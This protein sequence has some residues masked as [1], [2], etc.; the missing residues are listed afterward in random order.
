MCRSRLEP[1]FDQVRCT[2][3]TATW[4]FP[5][6][7]DACRF[8]FRFSPP[9]VAALLALSAAD[10]A[11]LVAEVEDYTRRCATGAGGLSMEIPFLVATGRAG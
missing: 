5:S 11:A 7:E 3:R 8:V 2:T 6:P 4:R 10:G 1:H 9:H